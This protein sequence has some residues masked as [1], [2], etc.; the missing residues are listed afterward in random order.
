MER[1]F[2]DERSERESLSSAPVKRLSGLIRQIM[3]C[4]ESEEM[5]GIDFLKREYIRLFQGIIEG[6]VLDR[7]LSESEL[8]QLLTLQ[9]SCMELIN[10]KKRCLMAEMKKCAGTREGVLAYQSCQQAV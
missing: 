1:S 10:E 4:V 2:T 5:A 7:G 3:E 8:K 6:D 9:Q